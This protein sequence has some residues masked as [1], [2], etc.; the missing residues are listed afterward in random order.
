MAEE[1]TDEELLEQLERSREEF[2]D[3]YRE[4]NEDMAMVVRRVPSIA[5]NPDYIEERAKL[6]AMALGLLDRDDAIR[7]ALAEE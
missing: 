1:P 5:E 6:D 4:L 2:V 3:A 7:E